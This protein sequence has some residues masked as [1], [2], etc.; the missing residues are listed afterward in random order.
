MSI[1]DKPFEL[2]SPSVISDEVGGE[3]LA[4]NLN[5][6]AYYVVPPESLWVWRAVTAGVPGRALLSGEDDREAALAQY[7]TSL[8]EAGLVREATMAKPAPVDAEAWTAADLAISEHTDMADLLGLDPIHDV[9]EA[10]GWPVRPD[11]S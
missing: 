1:L 4:I 5:T 3:T 8:Q 2:D 7:V 10:V 9:D 6:G 11:A